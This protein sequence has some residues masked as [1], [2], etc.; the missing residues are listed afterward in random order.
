MSFYS[1]M[2]HCLPRRSSKTILQSIYAAVSLVLAHVCLQR[3]GKKQ[4]KKN[5]K[6]NTHML[7]IILI[8]YS[9]KQTIIL[10]P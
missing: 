1:C 5:K 9:S 8:F 4:T 6:N 10:K 2:H 7:R 3:Q